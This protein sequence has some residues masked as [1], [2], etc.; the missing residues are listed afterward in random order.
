MLPKEISIEYICHNQENQYFDRKSARIKPSDIAKHIVAFANANGGIL[1]IGVED[2]GQVTGFNYSGAK[3]INDFRDIPYSMC[4]GR[5]SFDCKEEVIEYNNEEQT[6]LFFHINPS[7]DEVIKT[8]DGKVYLRVGDKSK[9]LDHSQITQLEYDK[10][11]RYFEDV[12]VE[13]S[14]YDDVD[15][16]LLQEYSK[17]L[18]T[19]LS[20]KE[21][22]EARGLFRNN[23]LTNAGVLLFSKYPS[24]FLP[25]ARLRFLKYDGLKMET[26]RRLNIIKELN[27]DYAIPRI[28]QE[29]RNAINLQLREFQYLDD[30]GKF[31]IIPEYPE[32]A[33]FEGIVNALTHRNYSMRGDCIRVSMY[34]DRI[35]IF[36]PGHLPNIVNLENMVNTRYSRNPR[37]ARI[38]S[39]FGW[40]KELNEGVKR[41]YDEMQLFYLNEPVYSEPNGNAVLLVLENSITSRQLRNDDKISSILHENRIND[42]N[43]YGL[44][45][46]QYLMS[47]PSITLK[48]TKELLSRGDTL[49]RKQLQILTEMKIIEWHGSNKSDPNQYYSLIEK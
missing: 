43:E 17:I 2:D 39:E 33:W 25:N 42:L 5:I 47:N 38:L 48:K 14:S 27:F 20:G 45:I 31:R 4:K 34:D 19:Q 29:I 32:F 41:I 44:K 23:H 24:K 11:E 36:S 21:I 1:A 46:V 16:N 13:D 6:V 30:N 15:E 35:E 22:L 26:G 49:C 18:N 8:T 7:T 37:I 9:L 10:G 3:S 12:L 28:I 40:V